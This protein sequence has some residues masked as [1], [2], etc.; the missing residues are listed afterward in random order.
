MSHKLTDA[1]AQ[2]LRLHDQLDKAR[3]AQSSA[4]S[5]ACK[6]QGQLEQVQF[7][8]DESHAKCEELEQKVGNGSEQVATTGCHKQCLSY[9]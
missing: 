3:A 9:T 7:L 2:Q 8:L 5:Q 4:E 1:K 6:L